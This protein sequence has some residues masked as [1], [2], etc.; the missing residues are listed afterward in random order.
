MSDDKLLRGIEKYGWAV[1]L[2]E[3]TDYL[4]SFAYTVGLSR[5]YEHPEL[6]SFGLGIDN[7]ELE[8]QNKSERLSLINA[9][10][11]GA[12]IFLTVEQFHLIDKVLT[13]QQWKPLPVDEWC[14][15]FEVDPTKYRKS[16]T[17][18]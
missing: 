8:L 9:G 16:H 18:H 4:P 1:T 11:D 13:D 3:A 5:S 17:K 10:N 7:L 2:I 14:K 6:I 12:A 15:V